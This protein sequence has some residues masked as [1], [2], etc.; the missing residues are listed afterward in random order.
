ME[1][2]GLRA[3]E[4]MTLAGLSE[5]Q[6]IYTPRAGENRV[7]KYMLGMV[8]NHGKAPIRLIGLGMILLDELVQTSRTKI[9]VGN[10]R[11]RDF[12]IKEAPGKAFY[13]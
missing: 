9:E 11:I 8:D 1:F 2:G 12:Y 4:S 10:K 7:Q 5:N 6:P 13:L 3:R